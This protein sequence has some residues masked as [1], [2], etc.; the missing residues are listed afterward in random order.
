MAPAAAQAR[1]INLILDYTVAGAC[2]VYP[3]YPKAG[4]RGNNIGWTIAP[5]DVVG[6]QYNVTR[7]GAMVSK[8]KSRKPPHPWGGFVQGGCI[9]PSMGGEPSPTPTSHYPAGRRIPNRLLQGRS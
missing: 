3:N 6:W 1:S 8:K 5:G 2:P 9:G 4:V 7:T